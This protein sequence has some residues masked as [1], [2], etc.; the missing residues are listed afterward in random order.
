[1]TDAM[2]THASRVR[3]RAG[4]ERD[5]DALV[6]GLNDWSVAQW[7]C[8]PPYPYRAEDAE[9]FIEGSTQGSPPRAYVVADPD[10]DQLMG[11]VGM[12][13]DGAVAELGYW[14]LPRHHGQGL[15]REAVELMFGQ[16]ASPPALVF[17]RVD[18]ENAPSIAVL[19][20]LGFALVCSEARETPTRRGSDHV[21]RFE[22]RFSAV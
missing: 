8:A 12:E 1:M 3:L 11:V 6:E 17:A 14:L 2:S 19:G 9:G 5:V 16:L 15:T 18:P 13:G 20:K 7:L 21:L 4:T 22:R 10:S